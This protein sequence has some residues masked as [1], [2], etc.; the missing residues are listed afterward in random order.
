MPRS[1]NSFVVAL[2]VWKLD[3]LAHSLHQLIATTKEL[4]DRGIH[5]HTCRHPFWG[6]DLDALSCLSDGSPTATDVSPRVS[7]YVAPHIRLHPGRRDPRAGI[8]HPGN[9]SYDLTVVRS[10]GPGRPGH[11][12]AE[13]EP[14]P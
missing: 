7:A 3:R 10:E 1:A 4:A 5:F 6:R 2:V 8:D 12:V 13:P 14:F 9:K 11:T